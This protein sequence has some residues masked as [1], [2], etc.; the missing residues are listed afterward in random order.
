MAASVAK[1]DVDSID[2]SGE[3]QGGALGTPG[4][5]GSVGT[6]GVAGSASSS[7]S[8][9]GSSLGGQEST[10]GLAPGLNGTLEELVLDV[11][12]LPRLD[13]LSPALPQQSAAATTLASAA[14]VPRPS[15]VKTIRYAIREG[16]MIDPSDLAATSLAADAQRR[17]GG[18][19]RQT[20]DRAVR[21]MAEQAGNSALLESGQVLLAPEVVQIQFRYFDGTAGVEE[22]NMQERG[23]M[24]TAID[25]RIW[26][27]PNDANDA[28]LDQTSRVV[29]A[30]GS[31]TLLSNAHMYSQTIDLPLAQSG[32]TSGSASSMSMESTGSSESA[33][34]SGEDSGQFGNQLQ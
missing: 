27:A 30:P 10:T 18:L 34:S 28:S 8:T 22:W 6:A 14:S 11:A 7:M 3:F 23:A 31:R 12:R 21:Q 26:L 33:G 1:F 9:D 15:D 29:A 13:E 32:G 17:A 5:A 16:A 24:P 2:D 19:V 4:G 20:I 25:V